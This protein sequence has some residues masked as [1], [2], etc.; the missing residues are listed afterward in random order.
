MKVKIVGCG[1]SGITSAILL[2]EMRLLG[3]EPRPGD[4]LSDRL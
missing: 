2:K 4:Y 3:L 1:L